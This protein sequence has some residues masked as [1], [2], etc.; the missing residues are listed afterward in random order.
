MC[1]AT[2]RAEYKR[3]KNIKMIQS[4]TIYK[5]L[6]TF[7][8]G[9]LLSCNNDNNDP[10]PMQNSII[11]T[12]KII[13]LTTNGTE[14]LQDELNGGSP[15]LCFWTILVTET[16]I[17]D[18]GFSGANCTTQTIGET[19]TYTLNGTTLTGSN[20]GNP[21]EIIELTNSTLKYIQSYEN[22]GEN[23]ID[24]YTYTKIE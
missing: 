18:I 13:S 24:I 22:S 3:L 17:T 9:I 2:K 20:E 12:W 1:N 6:L 15:P 10:E 5:L 21:Y 7:L 14:T 16:T 4:K 19:E 8:I 11:G 23:Y